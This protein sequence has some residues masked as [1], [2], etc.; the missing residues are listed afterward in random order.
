MCASLTPH[1][2]RLL[3]WVAEVTRVTGPNGGQGLH[4]NVNSV[5]GQVLEKE[6]TMRRRR[7]RV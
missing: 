3:S 5:E 1:S 7:D 6:V 2:W 4:G